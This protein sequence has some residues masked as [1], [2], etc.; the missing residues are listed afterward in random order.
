M[1]T[2]T[3]QYIVYIFTFP[4]VAFIEFSQSWENCIYV[5]KKV[6]QKDKF[7]LQNA[8]KHSKGE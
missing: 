6:N 3:C 2:F 4:N 8:V 1:S 5:Q 7:P